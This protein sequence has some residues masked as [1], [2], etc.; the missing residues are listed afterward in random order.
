MNIELGFEFRLDIAVKNVLVC[1]DVRQINGDDATMFLYL[2]L[3]NSNISKE[4]LNTRQKRMEYGTLGLQV[5]LQDGPAIRNP[6]TQS[7]L[8][9]QGPRNREAGTLPGIA[10]KEIG[11]SRRWD[12]SKRLSIAFCESIESILLVDPSI[13][14]SVFLQSRRNVGGSYFAERPH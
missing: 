11:C 14:D 10:D 1:G 8:G 9:S 2:C 6:S 5:K 4:Q 3:N 12:C 13:P 7:S